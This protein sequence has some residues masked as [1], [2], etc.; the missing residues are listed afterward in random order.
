MIETLDTL[1]RELMLWMNYDGGA[2]QDSLW[3]FLSG[4]F[5]W[6]PLYLLLVWML[7][8]HCTTTA[9]RKINWKAFAMLLILTV[10][11][12]ALSDQIASGIIKHWVERPRPSRED[13][14]IADLIHIVNDYRGGHYGF[15]SSHAAN[16]MAIALWFGLLLRKRWLCV[17]LG[18]WVALNCYSRIYLGVHYPGDILGGVLVGV[19]VAL[20]VY[21]LIYR[22][23]K[24]GKIPVFKDFFNAVFDDLFA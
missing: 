19:A 23:A 16:T 4:K 9:T 3:Y 24:S 12:V 21:Y 2:L 14:G 13:S 22:H 20:F 6:I 7:V 17:V 18:V 5:T 8:K 11:V 10:V 15:V 1:D